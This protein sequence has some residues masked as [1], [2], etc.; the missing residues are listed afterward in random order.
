VKR[1][2]SAHQSWIIEGFYSDI[3]EPVLAF[4]DKLIFL[5]PGIDAC[6]AHCRSRPWEPEPFSSWQEQDEHLDGLIEGVKSYEE[7]T[8]D[9]GLSR[10]RDLYESFAGKKR[11]LTHPSAYESVGHDAP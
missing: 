11:E 2:I 3:I 5:N 10:Q 9:S 1:W 7:R 4:C 8:D 6:L